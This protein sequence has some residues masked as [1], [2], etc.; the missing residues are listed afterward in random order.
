MFFQAERFF[1]Q[2]Q[3]FGM[4]NPA[5][6]ARAKRSAPFPDLFPDTHW[7]LVTTAGAANPERA[8]EALGRLCAVYRQ[9]IYRW[10]R[11]SGLP[12][13]AAEDAV[14]DFI[15]HMLARGG[16]TNLTP[17][18]ARFR[19]YLLACLR[20]R[21]RDRHEADQAAKRGGGADHTDLARMD[22][23]GSDGNWD[24]ELD[25][26]FALTVHRRSLAEVEQAWQKSGR[27]PRFVALQAFVLQGP[28]DGEYARAG[29]SLGLSAHQV[30][31][32]VFDLREAY[33]TA[34]RAEVAQT[35][36]PEELAGEVAHLVG[37]LAATH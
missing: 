19:T 22:L 4:N 33:F 20:N 26:E 35:V 37:I 7:S 6:S 36:A 2:H 5:D 18:G 1:S 24:R 28:E 10:L 3:S 9:P 34:F 8:L 23:A 21:M 25:R 13:H 12:H 32:L 16:L 29:V 11:A 31:R 27:H 17:H 14:Q 30:K 15:Q